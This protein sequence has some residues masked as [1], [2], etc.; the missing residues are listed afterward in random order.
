[1]KDLKFEELKC[2]FCHKE[3]SKKS[4]LNRHITETHLNVYAFTCTLCDK[5]FKRKSHLNRH[6]V[7]Y[8][9]CLIKNK[10]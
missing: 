4:K 2:K 1:M 8:I 5:T 7:I 6:L 9:N 3:F 10:I